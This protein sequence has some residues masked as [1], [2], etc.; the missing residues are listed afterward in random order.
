MKDNN[1]FFMHKKCLGTYLAIFILL[2]SKTQT[3]A[4]E[5]G[6]LYYLKAYF[7]Q[8]VWWRR[9]ENNMEI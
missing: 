5:V 8:V 3:A 2:V 9:G 1:K 6:N 4:L 7:L